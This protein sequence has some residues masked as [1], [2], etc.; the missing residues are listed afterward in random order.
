MTTGK[1]GWDGQR[2]FS[3]TYKQSRWIGVQYSDCLSHSSFASIAVCRSF[4]DLGHAELTYGWS[5]RRYDICAAFCMLYAAAQRSHLESSDAS[6]LATK[7]RSVRPEDG[8]I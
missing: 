5:G 7:T 3:H 8:G 6:Q 4:H 2:L 1:F